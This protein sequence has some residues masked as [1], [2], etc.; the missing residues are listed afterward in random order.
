MLAK[1]DLCIWPTS[2]LCANWRIWGKSDPE[3]RWYPTYK[4]C[5]IRWRPKTPKSLLKASAYSIITEIFYLCKWQTAGKKLYIINFVGFDLWI[6]F[7]EIYWLAK[8]K[9]TAPT[10]DF[11]KIMSL[12]LIW[13][14]MLVLGTAGVWRGSKRLLRVQTQNTEIWTKELIHWFIYLRR[15]PHSV[16]VAK[17]HSMDS[18][19]FWCQGP[20]RIPGFSEIMESASGRR[21]DLSW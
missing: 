18:H 21:R 4:I 6:L 9:F 14:E 8:Y 3:R 12:W 19:E 1:L 2:P 11:L 15:P 20:N 10:S 16:L 5:R 7:I 13:L 17:V